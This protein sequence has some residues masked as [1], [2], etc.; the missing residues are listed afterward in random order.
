MGLLPCRCLLSDPYDMTKEVVS[1]HCEVL[2]QG[3][4]IQRR[5]DI[6]VPVEINIAMR[7][8]GIVGGT[9]E[10]GDG[11]YLGTMK[12]ISAGGTYIVSKMW[13]EEG[14]HIDFTLEET[15]NPIELSVEVLRVVE[16]TDEEGN[17]LYGHGCRF[18]GLTRAA[19]SHVRNF[20]YQKERE[21]YKNDIW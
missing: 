6:K 10:L 2:E 12:D 9:L 8:E 5:N 15:R 19:E 7:T 13:I 1:F 21:L 14:S 20:V 11:G 17:K 3:E 4:Q 18:I 16:L